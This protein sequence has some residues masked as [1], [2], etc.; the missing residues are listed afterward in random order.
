MFIG[1]KEIKMVMEKDEKTVEVE[2][3]D[4]KKTEIN[5]DLLELIQTEVE[6][7]GEVTDNVKDYFARK[8]L[9]ELAY[10]DL[11]YYFAGY[12]S[13]AMDVLSHNLREEL[14]AKTFGCT[15]GDDIPLIKLAS[16]NSLD[17]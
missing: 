1:A 6:G 2:F 11:K 8:F 3:S 13:T 16:V 4:G 5:K 7:T 17:K 9:A 14:L 10:Y 12:V 15:G